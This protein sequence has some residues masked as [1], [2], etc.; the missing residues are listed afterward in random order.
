MGLLLYVL[1]KRAHLTNIR[2]QSDTGLKQALETTCAT[3]V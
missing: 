1:H 3:S 2:E